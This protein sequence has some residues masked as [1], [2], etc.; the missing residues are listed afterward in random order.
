MKRE[1]K[2]KIILYT[3]VGCGTLVI[4]TGVRLYILS[5]GGDYFL[6][7]T[8][9]VA[10]SIISFAIFYT[11]KMTIEDVFDVLLNKLF[12]KNREKGIEYSNTILTDSIKESTTNS[13]ITNN[14]PQEEIPI[15]II[16]KTNMFEKFLVLEK[17]LIVDGYLNEDLYWIDKSNNGRKNKQKLVCFLTGLVDSGYFLSYRDTNIKTY[18]EMR[19]KIELGENFQPARRKQ[20]ITEYKTTFFN[21][22]F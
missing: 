1:S 16:F 14:Q 19:Y 17:K 12:P 10:G 7:N 4:G 13:E 3:I 22:P 11:L 5:I 15:D 18:F 21:Y 6:A 8:M 9:F 2:E 20:Y